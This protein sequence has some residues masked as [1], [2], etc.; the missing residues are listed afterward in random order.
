MSAII[1]GK[2]I[3]LSINSWKKQINAFRIK[4]LHQSGSRQIC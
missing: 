3:K 2:F 1:D 4:Q